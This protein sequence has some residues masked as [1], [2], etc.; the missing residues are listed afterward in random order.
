MNKLN[1]KIAFKNFSFFIV[2]LSFTV[3]IYSC[4]ND[5]LK[6]EEINKVEVPPS[7]SE[8]TNNKVK[9]INLRQDQIDE[10]KIKTIGIKKKITTHN[11]SVPGFVFPA[12]ENISVISAPL[13][14]RVAKIYAHEGEKVRKGQTLLE[15]E[16]IEYGNLVAEYLQAN[17]DKIYQENKLNRIKLLV[18]KKI[19]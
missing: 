10:L 18:D 7:I 12:P 9:Y 5:E 17:A 19:S 16:S 14:G 2:L 4:G 1:K 8:N 11:L 15:L 13:D 3:F 6:T